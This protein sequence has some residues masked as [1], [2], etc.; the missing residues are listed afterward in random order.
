MPRIDERTYAFYTLWE[1]AANQRYEE[2]LDSGLSIPDAIEAVK[3]DDL[4]VSDELVQ[5]W[6]SEPTE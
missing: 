5:W 1:C 4:R 2:Y 6:L 3:R